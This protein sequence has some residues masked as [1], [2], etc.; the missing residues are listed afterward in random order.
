MN[1][2]ELVIATNNEGKLREFRRLLEPMGVVVLSAKDV[3]ERPF[4]VDET[5]DTFAANAELKASALSKA[6]GRAALADDSG[7]EVDAL[8]GRPG[9][10]SARFAGEHATDSENNRLL[11]EQLESVPDIDRS[12]RFRC[13]IALYLPPDEVVIVEAASEG[14]ILREPRG[15]AGFGYDPLFFVP[16]LG[17]SFAEL[18]ASEKDAISH[19]G[20]ALRKLVE[21]LAAGT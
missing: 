7:L 11:L 8:D 18:A 16:A 4:D 12:A 3:L 14:V 17:K 1:V 19:R 15:T 6:T 5:G 21:T 2:T 20:R 13:A 9:V 10:R